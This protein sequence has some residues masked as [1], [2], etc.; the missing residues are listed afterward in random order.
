MPLTWKLRFEKGVSIYSQERDLSPLRTWLG[1]TVEEGQGEVSGFPFWGS[2][3]VRQSR[4]S[5]ALIAKLH[6]GK[7]RSMCNIST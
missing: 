6:V 2:A 7:F 3:G 4:K 1:M 5:L